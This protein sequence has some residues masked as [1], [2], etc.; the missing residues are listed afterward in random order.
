M[1]MINKIFK[2]LYSDGTASIYVPTRWD[3]TEAKKLR[4]LKSSD[5]EKKKRMKNKKQKKARKRNR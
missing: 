4:R 3:K 1:E 5:L 2:T